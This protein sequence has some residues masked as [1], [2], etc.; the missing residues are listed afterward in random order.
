MSREL[1]VPCPVQLVWQVVT[2]LEHTAWRSDLRELKKLDEEHFVEVSRD[3]VS[4]RVTVTDCRPLCRYALRVEGRAS[5]GTREILLGEE[6]GR[7]VVTLR[8]EVLGRTALISLMERLYL[9]QFGRE[10]LRDLNNELYRLVHEGGDGHG[11]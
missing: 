11:A 3:G 4:N 8:C 9:R 7:T 1:R 2:D 6:D 10:Y 5:F